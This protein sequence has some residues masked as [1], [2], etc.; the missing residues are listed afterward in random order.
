MIE[1]TITG[2]PWKYG[3]AARR[4]KSPAARKGSEKGGLLESLV[5]W[6]RFLTIN[7]YKCLFGNKNK[8]QKKIIILLFDNKRL[9]FYQLE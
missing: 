6:P 7:K 8:K 4:T 5:G 1:T 2:R 3:P 9:Y